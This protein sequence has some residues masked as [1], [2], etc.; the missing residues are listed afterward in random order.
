MGRICR[1]ADR[2]RSAGGDFGV[3]CARIADNVG[4]MTF[5]AVQLAKILAGEVGETVFRSLGTAS[6]AFHI[7]EINAGAVTLPFDI[8]T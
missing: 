4:T 5:T 6:R 8:Y 1:V 7:I 3:P 2:F